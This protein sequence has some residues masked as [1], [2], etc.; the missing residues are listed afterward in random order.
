MPKPNPEVCT[1][2]NIFG[3]IFEQCPGVGLTSNLPQVVTNNLPVPVGVPGNISEVREIV[4][5]GATGNVTTRPLNSIVGAWLAS[6]TNLAQQE[7]AASFTFQTSNQF[8]SI[9]NINGSLSP[10]IFG[11]YTFSP[12]QEKF[13]LQPY[14]GS[15]EVYKIVETTS[16]S[17][18]VNGTSGTMSFVR[19]MPRT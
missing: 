1:K 7:F 4:E 19:V 11:K 6:G 13:T 8:S 2:I 3:V 10:P 18:K 12:V 17:F 16:D 9:V 15:T 5:E 14:G